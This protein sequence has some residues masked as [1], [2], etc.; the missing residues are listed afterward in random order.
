MYQGP[1]W[2]A[3]PIR[4]TKR[5]NFCE[6]NLQETD[7]FK[8]FWRSGNFSGGCCLT[9][10]RYQIS[11]TLIQTYIVHILLNW[12]TVIGANHFDRDTTICLYIKAE[13]KFLQLVPCPTWAAIDCV[14]HMYKQQEDKAMVMTLYMTV[15][16][17]HSQ[18]IMTPTII[19]YITVVKQLTLTTKHKTV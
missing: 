6:Q 17:Q 2:S 12:H 7:Q 1:A 10:S 3:I 15:M 9:E 19:I 13:N 11:V 4:N 16:K 14:F 5:F 18:H 8:T